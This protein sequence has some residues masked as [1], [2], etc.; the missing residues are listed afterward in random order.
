MAGNKYLEVDA[1]TGLPKQRAALDVS[2]GVGD[3]GGVVAL[4]T[5]GRIDASMMPAG[6]G[7]DTKSIAATENLA[8]GDLVN[9]YNSSGFKVRLADASTTGKEA[10]GFVLAAVTSGN[11]ATV[12]FEG[13]NTQLTGLSPGRKFLSPTT[14]GKV[15]AVV[16]STAGHVIQ[17]VGVATA[18]T[19]LNFEAGDP[20]ILA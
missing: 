17:F 19:E 10:H 9:I 12:Y 18:A 13:P 2:A 20:I 3:A 5:T 8:A 14:P 15:T 6:I 4:D 11:N 7:A 1:T 16:P